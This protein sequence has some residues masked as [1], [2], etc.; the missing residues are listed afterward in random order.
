MKNPHLIVGNHGQCLCGVYAG[1]N[2][3]CRDV[4]KALHDLDR[5]NLNLDAAMLVRVIGTLVKE[6]PETKTVTRD[7]HAP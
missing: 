3:F 5:E 4:L 1:R 2:V 7:S 6:M